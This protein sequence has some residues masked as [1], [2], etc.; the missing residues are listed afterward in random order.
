MKNYIGNLALNH[1][2]NTTDNN[3]NNTTN[4]NS[5]GSFFSGMNIPKATGKVIQFPKQDDFEVQ[6]AKKTIREVNRVMRNF[7]RVLRGMLILA[8]V[9]AVL[10]HFAPEARTTLSG[11][12]NF[13]EKIAMPILNWSFSLAT[14]VYL[15]I[16][17]LPIVR[18]LIQA[19][20]N[21][22]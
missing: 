15:W 3:A 8:I 5:Y 10:E 22:V 19:L 11:I 13:T 20:A 16:A 17:E 21:L 4:Q 14:K 9:L 12:Y 18:N 2:N 1:K 7:G 6:V